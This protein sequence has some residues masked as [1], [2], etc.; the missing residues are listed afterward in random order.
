[1]T[2]DVCFP[3]QP[4]FN[5]LLL[6]KKIQLHDQVLNDHNYSH[7]MAKFRCAVCGIVSFCR[8]WSGI[9]CQMLM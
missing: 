2:L 6:V 1:M 5:I 8:M 3:M 7:K 9:C 4:N